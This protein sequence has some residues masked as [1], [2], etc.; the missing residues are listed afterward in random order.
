MKR[1]F[2]VLVAS[3]GAA[4]FCFGHSKIS[5]DLEGQDPE[6]PVQVIIQ[7]QQPPQSRQIDAVVRKGGRHRGMLNVVNGAVYSVKAKA[8][9][10]LANDPEVKYISVDRALKAGVSVDARL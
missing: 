2:V 6:A 9:A 3:L 5:P 8:L 10:D 4:S 7:Y 1:N